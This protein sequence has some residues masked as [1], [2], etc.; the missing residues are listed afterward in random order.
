MDLS[1]FASTDG[2]IEISAPLRD[3]DKPEARL[4]ASCDAELDTDC[5]QPIVIARKYISR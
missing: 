1:P 5:E 2:P 4:G 3:A